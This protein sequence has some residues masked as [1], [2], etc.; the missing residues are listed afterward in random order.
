MNQNAEQRVETS[1]LTPE[2]RRPARDPLSWSGPVERHMIKSKLE[3]IAPVARNHKEKDV[4][5]A[6]KK[7]EER[8]DRA[9]A[10]KHVLLDRADKWGRKAITHSKTLITTEVAKTDAKQKELLKEV[11]DECAR[12][13]Q[14]VQ[15]KA[16]KEM[17]RIQKELL[18]AESM[19]DE[20]VR[21]GQASVRSKFQPRFFVITEEEA[22]MRLR[23][24]S[25]TISNRVADFAEDIKEF[26]LDQ[27][28]MLLADRPIILV[29]DGAEKTIAV[30]GTHKKERAL[31]GEK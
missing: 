8:E 11:S 7:E 1:V 5:A 30:P 23:D 12:R 28:E 24:I 20:E 3:K 31:V 9:A 14:Q 29:H 19:I 4:L 25:N 18:E 10:A 15:A 22:A 16:K 17:A 26:S 6:I 2:Q 27:L 13:K 21:T